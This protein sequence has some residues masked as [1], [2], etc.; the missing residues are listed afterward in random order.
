MTLSRVSLSAAAL[1]LSA[2][3]ALGCPFDSHQKTI[4]SASQCPEGQTISPLTGEC[5]LQSSS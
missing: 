2:V 4:D 5:V 1:V 3:A